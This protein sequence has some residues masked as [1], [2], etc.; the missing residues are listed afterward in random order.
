MKA[1]QC[2]CFSEVLFLGKLNRHFKTPLCIYILYLLTSENWLLLLSGGGRVWSVSLLEVRH[3][4]VMMI[5]L[6]CHCICLLAHCS[7]M[8]EILGALTVFLPGVV[9]AVLRE[10]F[11]FTFYSCCSQANLSALTRRLHRGSSLLGQRGA[12]HL[13]KNYST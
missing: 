3:F 6:L 12:I 5:R 4:C 13:Q 7:L 9:G 8:L 1:F 2:S 11:D 10:K